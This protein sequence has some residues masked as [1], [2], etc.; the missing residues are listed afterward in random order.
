MIYE[1]FFENDCYYI[2]KKQN[3]FSEKKKLCIFDETLITIYNR[4]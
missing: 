2:K 3:E 4:S 1:L